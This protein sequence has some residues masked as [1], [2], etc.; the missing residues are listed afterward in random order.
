MSIFNFLFKKKI[1]KGDK[2][3]LKESYRVDERTAFD[4]VATVFYDIYIKETNIRVGSIDL[5]FTIEGDMYY[6][7]HVGYSIIKEYRG[8]NY[9][10]YACKVLFNIAATEFNMKELLI[11][12][13]PENVASYKTLEKLGGEIIDFVQVPTHHFLY[14]KGE[15]TK[16]IFKYELG[17]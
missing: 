5:R 7:G 12:C 8:N 16:Y 15:T 2:V 11:T 13:S 1:Y 6:Y 9:A 3:Y 14:K 17:L 4:G 10:Y